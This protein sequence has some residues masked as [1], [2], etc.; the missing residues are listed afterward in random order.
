MLIDES[1]LTD[2]QPVVEDMLTLLAEWFETIEEVELTDGQRS[3]LADAAGIL[4]AL[5]QSALSM[6]ICEAD[7]DDWLRMDV[8][9][10]WSF[11]LDTD[12]ALPPDPV[13]QFVMMVEQGEQRLYLQMMKRCVQV[14]ESA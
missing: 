6:G 4:E 7:F 13:Q 9:E 2:G 11:L 14:A 10:N 12:E 3:M 8:L 5:R 1:M